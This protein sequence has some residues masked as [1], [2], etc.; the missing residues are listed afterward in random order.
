MAKGDEAAAKILNIGDVDSRIAEA[1]KAFLSKEEFRKE[2]LVLVTKDSL[3]EALEKLV[4]DELL[5]I[6]VDELL[7]QIVS[8][9]RVEEICLT[10]LKKNQWEDLKPGAITLQPLT[11]SIQEPKPPL[12]A[13]ILI[14][15]KFRGSKPKKTET[16]VVHVPTE[17]DLTPED[18]LNYNEYEDRIVIVA[19]DGQKH[20]VEL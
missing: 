1:L 8:E 7:K 12:P 16:G 19:A 10:L 3:A 4:T 13:E 14:G 5:Q 20:T 2:V 17:R 15:L 18:V 9:T 6:K 11:T